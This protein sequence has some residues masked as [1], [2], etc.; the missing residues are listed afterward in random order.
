MAATALD[1]NTQQRGPT[2]QIAL[3]MGSGASIPIGVMVCV[4]TPAAGAVNAADTAGFL[5]MG[6]SHQAAVQ[7]NGDTKIVV[8]KGIYKMGNNGNITAAHIG[9]A[10]TVVDN[11]TVGLAADTT[12]DVIAG[13]VTEVDSDGVWIDMTQAKIPAA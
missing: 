5:V 7:A 10:V 8:G 9:I 12:N 4:A 6:V 2:R 3:P 1:R 11:Q 13:Y